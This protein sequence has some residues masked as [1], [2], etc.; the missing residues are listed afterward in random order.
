MARVV[1]VI[2]VERE[3]EYFLKLDWTGGIELI[4]Q[5][6]FSSIVIPAQA[7]NALRKPDL[8]PL[9]GSGANEDPMQV[10]DNHKG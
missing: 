2:W 4:P 1:E 3:G 7:C 9:R 5:E 6:N 8:K 10:G